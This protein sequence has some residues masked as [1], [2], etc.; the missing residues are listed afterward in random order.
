MSKPIQKKCGTCRF[1][2]PR[3][4]GKPFHHSHAYACQWR[5]PV[6]YKFPASMR[7]YEW[8]QRLKSL[9]EGHIGSY[10]APKEGGDCNCWEPR[11]AP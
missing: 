2:R 7:G 8:A 6:E 4:D 9:S 10:M 5:M 11:N 3:S 1:L